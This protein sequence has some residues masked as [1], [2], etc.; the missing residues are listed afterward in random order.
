M[1]VR[2]SRRLD[3][4]KAIAAYLARD[5]RT[6][7]RWEKRA[8]LPVH[9]VPGEPSHSSVFAFTNELDGWLSGEKVGREAS[10]SHPGSQIG[11]LLWGVTGL[12]VLALS[13][14]MVRGFS[15]GAV[16]GA[17]ALVDL[18][19]DLIVARDSHGAAAW[20][21][22][23]PAGYSFLN[24]QSRLVDL[25]GTRAREVVV[26]ANVTMADR[27]EYQHGELFC[28][29]DAGMSE[30][31]TRLDD[32]FHFG[33]EAY[34]SP[35]VS[36]HLEVLRVDGER[37][38]LWSVAHYTW[39]PSVVIQVD[40]A[41]T[42]EGTFVNSGWINVMNVLER[43]E[44][45]LV[46]AG[47]VSNSQAGA[48]LAVLDSRAVSGH[49]PEPPSSRFACRDCPEG[50]PVRY[51]VFPPTEVNS[52]SGLPYNEVRRIEVTDHI[53]SVV[54][55]EGKP[56]S[57]V[58]WVFEFSHDFELLRAEPGDSYWPEHRLLRLQ[59]KIDH[60]E[61]DCPERGLRSVRSWTRASGWRTATAKTL[62]GVT[63]TN[64][65]P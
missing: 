17:V 56:G 55:L 30:W 21:Y 60:S 43:D 33:D 13:L 27:P 58:H 37:Q 35:W 29:T 25:H 11:R 26:A 19:G 53:I 46:L 20:T 24:L 44:S 64:D 65:V 39:W 34:S 41:G 42:V 47:G 8:G 5:T 12:V 62:S 51:L 7:M 10:S 28:L 50:E 54:V 23:H 48:A 57:G 16:G 22:A 31:S 40:S 38:I 1:P 6:V 4:W 9:R 14:L 2:P 15:G 61:D 52:A 36:K 3:S 45:D 59:G 32:T 49:S 18:A 63:T